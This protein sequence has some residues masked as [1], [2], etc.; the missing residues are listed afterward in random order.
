[1][2]VVRSLCSAHKIYIPVIENQL[3][4]NLKDVYF[5]ALARGLLRD[6]V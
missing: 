1:M 3:S 6:K 5:Q 4:L 2:G